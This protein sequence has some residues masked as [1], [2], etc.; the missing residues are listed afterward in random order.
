MSV[1][2]SP[3]IHALPYPALEAGNLSF[4]EGKYLAP[5]EMGKD[6]HSIKI[7]HQISGAPFLKALIE[8]K[9]AQFGCLLSVPKVGYRRLFLSETKKQTV[10]WEATIVGEPPK[11]RPVLVYTGEEKEYEF[12]GEHGV[13]EIWQGEKVFLPKGAKLARA[14]F[15][16]VNTSKHPFLRPEKDDTLDPGCLRVEAN[17]NEGFYFSIHAAPDVYRFIQNPGTEQALRLSILTAAVSRC[18]EILKNGYKEDD[19]NSNDAFSNLKILSDKLCDE[20]GSD[21]NDENFDPIHAATTLYPIHVPALA[22]EEDE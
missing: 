12:T 16:N 19:D 9:K 22:D 11:L 3:I 1:N 5:A 6:G 20:F 10:E 7:E 15:L 21:W 14:S 13:A 18:F 2:A 17:A 8:E 4:P